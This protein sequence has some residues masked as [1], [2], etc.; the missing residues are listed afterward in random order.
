MTIRQ[1][2]CVR[3]RGRALGHVLT[4]MVLSLMVLTTPAVAVEPDEIL[5]NPA[6]EARARDI[7]KNLRCLVCR[8]QSIDDSD[9]G[10][11]KDLRIVVRDRLTAGD[12]N[13]EVVDFVTDRYGEYVLLRPRFTMESA[14]LYLGGPFLLLLG[15]MAAWRVMRRRE[16]AGNSAVALPLS[17]EERQRL[18][19]LMGGRED[20]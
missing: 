12:T 2:P 18:D 16:N 3:R 17:A 20:G 4:G 1:W 6:L 19:A 5:A 13:A 15:G 8:N 11:A 10:L 14:A 7:S 9:A